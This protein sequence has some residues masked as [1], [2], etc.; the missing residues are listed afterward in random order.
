MSRPVSS[1][2]S[3]ALETDS[4]V[5]GEY[6]VPSACDYF[7]VANDYYPLAQVLGIA[8]KIGHSPRGKGR[9]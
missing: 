2:P 4:Y 3:V 7:E 6:T 5:V 8:V 9:H 1:V